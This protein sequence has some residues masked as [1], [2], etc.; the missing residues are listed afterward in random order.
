M[1]IERENYT[2]YLGDCLEVMKD[3]EQVDA[4]ITDPP[5]GVTSNP[6]DIAVDL[7]LLFEFPAVVLTSQQPYAAKV[8]TEHITRFRYEIIWDKVL[9]SGHLNAN[10]MPLR[11]H[12]NILVFGSPVFNPQKTKG[13]KSHGKGFLKDV[14]TNNNYG[15]FA[16]V[17]NKELH[18]LNKY[19]SSIVE[20]RKPHPSKSVHPT[21]KSVDLFMWL[22]LTY[23]NRG[24]TILDP[25]MG[26][27][28]TGVACAQL[29]RKFIGI[30]I[31]PDYFEIARKRIETAYAQKV[32]F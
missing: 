3:L 32:M 15:D 4:V 31:D 6:K 19:P 7:S 8:I 16:V 1:K 21:E 27:G 26:S 29:G 20:F 11:R 24:D 12:E 22:L 30:E 18:G 10:K 2:L 14:K 25:F 23:S 13:L 17:D 28:T 9:V 5:Y